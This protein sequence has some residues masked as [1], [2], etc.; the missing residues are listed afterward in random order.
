MAGSFATCSG[1]PPFSFAGRAFH[2][3]GC[4]DSLI[5]F[6]FE[7]ARAGDMVIVPAMEGNPVV[8]VVQSTEG[9]PTSTCFCS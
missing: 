5:A 3:C 8:L 7:I 6:M 1:P 2:V 9:S 4:G